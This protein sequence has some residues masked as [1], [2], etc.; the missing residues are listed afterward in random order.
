MQ[1]QEFVSIISLITPLFVVS[2][3]YDTMLTLNEYT[4]WRLGTHFLEKNREIHKCMHDNTGDNIVNALMHRQH[5][6]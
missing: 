6:A 5:E 3:M 4:K 2:Q 1:K